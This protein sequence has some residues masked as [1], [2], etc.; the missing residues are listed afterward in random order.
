M[1]SFVARRSVAQRQKSRGIFPL[2]ASLFLGAMLTTSGANARNQHLPLICEKIREGILH[3]STIL[4]CGI[5]FLTDVDRIFTTTEGASSNQS[6]NRFSIHLLKNLNTGFYNIFTKGV[7][8]VQLSFRSFL[9]Q[10]QGVL[11]F[12]FLSRQDF[13]GYIQLRNNSRL[14]ISPTPLLPAK[15]QQ[16]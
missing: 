6:N 2:P 10:L 15:K 11:P 9:Q 1:V 16:S 4:P 13:Q 5:I 3:K 8:H 7:R 14:L 12:P